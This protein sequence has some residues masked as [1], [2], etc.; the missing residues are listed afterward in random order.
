MS[1]FEGLKWAV[2]RID[3]NYW[4]RQSEDK[5]K[6]RSTRTSQNYPP[7]NPWLEPNKP[8]GTSERATNFDRWS[9]EGPRYPLSST[10]S[11]CPENLTPIGN[12]ILGPDGHLTLA[13]HQCC[14][15]LGL[16]IRCGQSS[17]FVWACPKQSLRTP[18]LVE[19]R[20]TYLENIP[21]ESDQP[22]KGLTVSLLLQGLT[23]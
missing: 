15:T 6:V 5:N 16:C 4:K 23:A 1:S 10:P 18:T 21:A 20:A 14:L 8:P 17:H 13:E 12:N 9:C 19:R 22:K 11:T 2:L 7:R 3:N